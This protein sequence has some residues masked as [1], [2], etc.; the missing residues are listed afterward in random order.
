MT[1][2]ENGRNI[3]FDYGILPGPKYDVNQERYVTNMR[4]P[5][6][7]YAIN[8]ANLKVKEASAV[9]EAQAS[10]AYRIVTPA[11]FEVTMKTR[12]AM[13]DI[14]SKMYDYVRD[15]VVFDLG[16]MY[17]YSLTNYYPDFRNC[18]F[19]GGVGWIKKV[20]GLNKSLKT[21]LEAI[22]EVYDSYQ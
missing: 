12:Y 6:E 20:A 3:S 7:I 14:S 11:I 19:A 4:Y 2:S 9:L 16:R 13:D 21:Q 15:G 8:S 22:M 18:I 5:Y 17:N 10:H 1:N